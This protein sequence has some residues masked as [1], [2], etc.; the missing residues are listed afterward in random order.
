MPFSFP[1]CPVCGG[2]QAFFDGVSTQ[3]SIYLTLNAGLFPD[4]IRLGALICLNCG[5]TELRPNPNDMPRLR[6]VVER[7]GV[8]PN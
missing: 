3:A 8:L 2:T 5:H 4:A 6:A 7:R 1:P